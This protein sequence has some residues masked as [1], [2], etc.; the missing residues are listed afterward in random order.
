MKFRANGLVFALLITSNLAF[1]A[2]ICERGLQLLDLKRDTV[3]AAAESI[4]EPFS[5]NRGYATLDLKSYIDLGWAEPLFEELTRL[6]EIAKARR[7][8]GKVRRDLL[9]GRLLHFKVLPK[10]Y[11][12]QLRFLAQFVSVI[13]KRAFPDLMDSAKFVEVDLRWSS[14]AFHSPDIQTWHVDGGGLSAILNLA[15]PGTEILGSVTNTGHCEFEDYYLE[16]LGKL[17]TGQIQ[18]GRLLIFSGSYNPELFRHSVVHRSP[19]TNEP[20]LLIVFRFESVR[21][22]HMVPIQNDPFRPLAKDPF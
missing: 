4:I 21:S 7:I 3:G 8:R 11:Q 6:Q 19:I 10:E 16:K 2:K 13:I 9:D 1:A 17:P 22:R 14:N 20:R 18:P 12:T 5:V 15:G